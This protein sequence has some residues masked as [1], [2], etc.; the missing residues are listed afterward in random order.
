[1]EKGEVGGRGTI[2]D[3]GRVGQAKK[4]CQEW[5]IRR[6]AI[7]LAG[8]INGRPIFEHIVIVTIVI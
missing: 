1:M 7:Y 5:T 4:A 6:Q 2:Q 8:I 3:K